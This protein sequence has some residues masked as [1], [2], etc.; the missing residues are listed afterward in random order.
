MEPILPLTPLKKNKKQL[1][2]CRTSAVPPR[3]WAVGPLE[4]GKLRYRSAE[5]SRWA[6][7]VDFIITRTHKAHRTHCIPRD[8]NGLTILTHLV[9]VP[10][11]SPVIGT[12]V[13]RGHC[14]HSMALRPGAPETQM[15]SVR[16]VRRNG[17][18]GNG[19]PPPN[20]FR[21]FEKKKTAPVCLQWYQESCALVRY[22]LISEWCI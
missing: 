3:S 14:S 2:V 4:R 6:P 5:R 1:P 19:R 21:S 16:P 18:R 10:F 17:V 8:S 13:S 9:V 11:W 20:I 15:W 7:W 12:P 22:N